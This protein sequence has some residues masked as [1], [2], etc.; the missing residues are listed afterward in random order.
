MRS[1]VLDHHGTDEICP[2]DT[3]PAYRTRSFG[4]TRAVNAS[5]APAVDGTYP[6]TF[7]HIFILRINET[8][9][10]FLFAENFSR[11]IRQCT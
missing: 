10:H 7:A 3:R 6:V 5:I 4:A 9:A 1:M 2:V 8:M 11:H